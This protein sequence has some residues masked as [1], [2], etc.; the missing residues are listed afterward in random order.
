MA[1]MQL[2]KHEARKRRLAG[3]ERVDKVTVSEILLSNREEFAREIG[4]LWRDAQ[5]RF[6]LI[7]RYLNQ[8]KAS[9]PHGEFEAMIQRDLPFSPSI[10][11]Q[12]RAVAQSLDN[13]RFIETELPP[14]YSTAYQITTLSEQE[15]RAARDQS[16][17]R[18]DVQRTEIMEFKRLMRGALESDRDRKRRHKRLLAER[19]R[20]MER[21]QQ[22]DQELGT[23]VIEGSAIA[24]TDEPS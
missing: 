17:I 16:L 18:P 4:H 6:L 10:G 2:S 15:L 24:V 9:L 8:A 5:H 7:G 22:I 19:K 1:V 13:G 3:D 12:L 11:Y 20:L 23:D 21:V 14:S